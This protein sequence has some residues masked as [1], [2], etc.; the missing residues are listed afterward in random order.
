MKMR[1]YIQRSVRRLAV[2]FI[3]LLLGTSAMALDVSIDGPTSI[4]QGQG[5]SYTA[6]V[7]GWDFQGDITY[8]WYRNGV[9][10]PMDPGPPPYVFAPSDLVNG[11][12]ISCTVYTSSMGYAYS[13][14]LTITVGQPPQFTAGVSP[15][16]GLG[17][18]AGATVVFTAS[19]N[20]SISSYQWQMNGSNVVG[21]TSSSFSTAAVSAAQLQTVRCYVTTNEFCI[22][23]NNATGSAQGIP[24]SVA[25]VVTPAISINTSTGTIC[26]GSPTTFSSNISNGG[27]SPGYQWMING[28]NVGGANGSSFT[29]SGLANGQ[30][31]SCRL[32]SNAGCTTTNTVTSNAVA[33]TVWPTTPMTVTVT[34]QPSTCQSDPA[35]FAATATSASGNINYHWQRNGQDIPVG[36]IVPGAPFPYILVLGSLNNGDV[37]TCIV[38]DNNGCEAPVTSGG[39][40]ANV[41]QRVPF[42]IAPN[43]TNISWCYGSDVTFTANSNFP[44]TGV[45]TWQMNG[46][47]VQGVTGQTF[48]TQALSADQLNSV[49]VSATAMGGCISN[50]QATGTVGNAPFNIVPILAPSVAVSQNTIP[51]IEGSPAT[52]SA[53]PVNGGP[54]PTYQWQLNGAD[55]SG[56]TGSSFTKTI[57]TGDDIQAVSVTMTTSYTCPTTPT[58]ASGTFYFKLNSAYWENMNYI[59]VHDILVPG[60]KEWIPADLLPTGQKLVKTTYYDGLGRP[61]QNVRKEQSVAGSQVSD[62]VQPLGYDALGRTPKSYLP[63]P[64]S[65]QPG[66][67]K[68]GALTEQ[69]QYYSSVYNESISYDQTVYDNSPLDRETNSK[70]SGGSWAA[71]QGDATAYQVNDQLADNVQMWSVGYGSTDYPVSSGAYPSGALFKTVKTDVKGKIVVEYRDNANQ[72]ILTKVQVDDNPADAYSGWSCTYTVYDDYGQRRYVIQPEGVKYLAGHGWSFATTDGPT[73]LA[74]QCFRYDYDEKGRTIS[75]KAPGAAPLQMIYDIRDRVVF[76]QDGNQAGMATPQWSATMYDLFDRPVKTL[77]YNT[78]ETRDNLQSDVTAEAGFSDPISAANQANSGV[79]TILRYLYYD[80]YSFAGAKSFDNSYTNGTA[81]SPSDPNVQP[82]AATGRT[83]GMFTGASVRVLGTNVFLNSTSY[84]DER[85]VK[86][87]ALEDNIKGGTD[88]TTIQ[89]HFGGAVLSTCKNHSAPGTGYNNYVVLSKYLFDNLFRVIGIQEQ[90]GTNPM[91]QVVSYE[92]D[93]L[94]RMKT[95]HFD[96]G[97][98]N[99]NSGHAELESL[100]YSYNI[101]SQITG[102][103]KDYALKTAGAY[104]KWG[105][106]FGLYLG[107]DN[108]DNVFAAGQLNGQVAGQLWNTQGDDAQRRYDY[109][110]DNMDRLTGAAFLEQQHPGDGWSA[111]KTDFSVSGVTYDLNGNLQSMVHKG[112]MPGAS[113]PIEIDHLVYSYKDYSNRLKSVTDQMTS[114]TFNGQSGDFKDGTNSGDDYV[115]DGNGNLVVDLN[116]NVQSLNNGA[117][118]TA[119]IRYNV[120][121]KPEE[122]RIIGKGT[123]KIVYSAEGEKLQRVFIP[124]SGG[125]A[126][127]TSYIDEF[128]YQES[129]PLTTSSPAPFS[130]TGVK[131]SYITFEE[132]RIRAVTAGTQSSSGGLDGTTITGNLSLLNGQSGVWDYFVEDYLGNVRMILTEEGHTALNTCT[133]ETTGGRPGIEDPVFGQTGGGNEVEATRTNTPSGWSAVNASASVSILGNLAG[134]VMGPNVLQKVMAG[135]KVA[136]SAIYYFQ[137]TGTGGNSNIIPNVVNS[138]AGAIAG[139]VTAGTVVHGNGTAIAGQ[140]SGNP[141][142]ISAVEPTGAGGSTPQAYLT[143]LFFD[144]RFQLVS[145]TDGGVVQKQVDGTWSTSTLPL[146]IP[147]AVAPKNGYV[148]VYLSNRSDQPVYFD[149]FAVSI[150]AGNILEENHYYPYGLKV[151]GIS[152]KRIPD[153]NEGLVKNNYLFN[154]KELIDDADLDWYDYGYRNYDPQIGRFTQLDPLA[155]DY[156]DLTPY[157]FAGGDPVANVD[158]DGLE[159][160]EVTSF[161]RAV[162]AAADAIKTFA[163]GGWFVTWVKDGVAYARIFRAAAPVVKEASSWASRLLKVARVAADFVPIVGG[164]IDVAEGIAKGDLLQV[165]M[166]VLSIGA[167]IVSGGASSLAKGAAK[168]LVKE[169][170]VI[171]AKDI[172]EQGVKDAAKASLREGLKEG[173]IS[174]VK[175]EAKQAVKEEAKTI[176]KQEVKEVVAQEAKQAST[177]S[178]RKKAVRDAWKEEKEMVKETGKGTREWSAAEKKQLLEKG[179]VKGYQGHHINNVKDHPHLAGHPD[180]VKFLNPKEH[181]A[182]H[183][184]NFKNKTTG[185]LIS[186][187]IE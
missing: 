97:Y 137:N 75:K 94:G 155:W 166:G 151:A 158:V 143:V 122:I 45:Y 159:P 46:Q 129:A 124:E 105:H 48:T 26:A 80:D 162:G 6:D 67:F 34:G 112:V 47:L 86:T 173:T 89:H 35:T 40:V 172:I 110:Y 54:Q 163:K 11:E 99:P 103:N 100:N 114:T 72:L 73:V 125:D 136:A 79:C 37:I 96:P 145:A 184:G 131:L 160:A 30:Q 88:V 56:A 87:Q 32:T 4:C 58:A 10:Q 108:K 169:G 39:F 132:G 167:D 119:G 23:G 111:T 152:S 77:L 62:I 49:T 63:Y 92:Y 187:K 71:S 43:F 120:L 44:T 50:N 55:V 186:R 176:A 51:A 164:V 174:A 144:E 85:G 134:H 7:S 82:I 102:I 65:T 91:K 9:Q 53:V 20:A 149:N 93:E 98:N 156:E 123:I 3:C 69:Q 84:Y 15:S 178:L 181:L 8:Y 12:T 133:M 130:G 14:T 70:E 157:Q 21:A 57:S 182:A 139:G 175:Q 2:F 60:I 17:F 180:N 90:Y 41:T 27:S 170:A 117:A 116:K 1:A 18:C 31:V 29:T 147:A 68:T 22:S 127:I 61:I 59:R 109:A 104:G 183:G 168:T 106:F 83:R 76:T 126:T 24:F 179:K 5:V 64:S 33:M 146:T 140:L 101:H 78:T 107:Y 95:R 115:Y 185:E 153:A 16:N 66:K 128:V 171:V 25:P 113:A 154:G 135:D 141:G 13:N 52:F 36:D 161:A 177:K 142:F 118:G 38:T 121:D 19:A 81:Y 150:S 42:T 28:S 138:L 74:E 165:G 148:Y